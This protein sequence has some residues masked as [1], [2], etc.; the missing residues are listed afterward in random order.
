MFE[1]KKFPVSVAVFFTLLSL[2]CGLLTW[3][4]PDF[5][6]AIIKPFTHGMDWDLVW[7]PSVTF[8]GL[9]LGLVD[10]FILSYILAWVFAKI[11]KSLK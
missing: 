9:I 3:I 7:K 2:V 11:Y 5:L 10:A 6:L 1:E 8:G 4:A